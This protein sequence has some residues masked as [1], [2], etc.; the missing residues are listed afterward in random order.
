MTQLLGKLGNL[1]DDW[2]NLIE[3]ETD[4]DFERNL[5]LSFGKLGRIREDQYNFSFV[6]NWDCSERTFKTSASRETGTVK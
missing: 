6:G 2:I 3:W 5:N 1:R 4:E